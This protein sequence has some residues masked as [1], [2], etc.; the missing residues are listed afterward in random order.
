[1]ELTKE[2]AKE[3]LEKQEALE[4]EEAAKELEAFLKERNLMID[5]EIVYTPEKGFK[6]GLRLLKC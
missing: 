5:V 2:Q 6:K 1:M 4:L 3:F